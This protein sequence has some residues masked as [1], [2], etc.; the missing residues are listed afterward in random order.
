MAES[1]E[2]PH[3]ASRLKAEKATA[4]VATWLTTFRDD[5]A[6]FEHIDANGDGQ[7]T[8]AEL[9]TVVTPFVARWPTWEHLPDAVMEL[10]DSAGRGSIYLHEFLALAA[11]HA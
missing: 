8:H 7:V 2:L 9:V 1:N 6:M 4:L 5:K 11:Q 3:E 10:G